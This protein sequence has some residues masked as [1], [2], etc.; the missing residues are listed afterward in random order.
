[1]TIDMQAPLS[2][3]HWTIQDPSQGA[4]WIFGYPCRCNSW[5]HKILKPCVFEVG[6]D[7]AGWLC[8]YRHLFLG[9]GLLV[10]LAGCSPPDAYDVNNPDHQIGGLIGGKPASKDDFPSAVLIFGNCTAAKVGPRQLLTAAHCVHDDKTNSLRPMYLPHSLIEITNAHDVTPANQQAVAQLVEVESTAMHPQW[11]KDCGSSCD[12][13]TFGP[14]VLGPNVPPDVAVVTLAEDTPSIPAAVVD[15]HTIA[16]GEGVVVTGYGCTKSLNEKYDYDYQQLRFDETQALDGEALNH[17]R[18]YVPMTDPRHDLVMASY[19]ITPGSKASVEEASLCPG[20]SGGPLYRIYGDQSIVVG[21]NA[22]YT[23]MDGSGV[24]MTNWHTRLDVMSRF[25]TAVFLRAQGVQLIEAL[26]GT[27]AVQA[28]TDAV[29]NG[30]ATLLQTLWRGN[31]GWLRSVPVT[32]GDIDWR[33]ASGWLGPGNIGDFPGSGDMQ[34]YSDVVINDGT[35]LLQ[36]IWRGDQGW[37]RAVPMVNGGNVDWQNASA[38]VGPGDIAGLP[39]SGDVQAQSEVI[40][41]NG[42]SLMQT[43]WRGNQSWLRA[44]PIVAGGNVDWKNATG[45]IG[46]GDISALPGAGDVQA[47]SDIVTSGGKTLL[48]SFWRGNQGWIRSIP[49]STDGA[50]DWKNATGWIGPAAP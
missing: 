8:M 48:Q 23:F 2:S 9:C 26:P 20:D 46:P 15:M 32:N 22:Y 19:V 30:G 47:Q 17:P 25:Q 40:I 11:V 50:V 1:M 18:S 14:N 44:V 39:G 21:V 43:W 3:Q 36:T 41:N 38:W 5:S 42:K 10:A 4:R 31:Q 45:W 6:T 35:T 49:I 37:F 16:T 29:I 33:N 7:N 34:S 27:G 24:S 13:D 28:Q 12:F